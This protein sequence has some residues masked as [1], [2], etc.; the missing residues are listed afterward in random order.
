MNRVKEYFLRKLDSPMPP[1]GFLIAYGVLIG[2]TFALT[3]ILG[4]A[5]VGRKVYLKCDHHSNALLKYVKHP[6]NTRRNALMFSLLRN[7]DTLK[8]INYS[9]T[10]PLVL[11]G[12]VLFAIL[13]IGN[14]IAPVMGIMIGSAWGPGIYYSSSLTNDIIDKYKQET[15]SRDYGLYKTYLD[16]LK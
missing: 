14:P 16:E 15:T 7:E 2:T 1:Y 5:Y 6:K 11:G 13:T 8:I 12:T 10:L 9:S 3:G 4:G